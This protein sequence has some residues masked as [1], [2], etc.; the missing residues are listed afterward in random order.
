M[1]MRKFLAVG[2]LITAIA[3]TAFAQHGGRTA[4]G[5]GGSHGSTGGRHGA[6]MSR[7]SPGRGIQRGVR[8]RY[9]GSPRIQGYGGANRGYGAEQFSGIGGVANR[10]IYAG[11]G[12]R[13]GDRDGD[14]RNRGYGWRYGRGGRFG[15]G[16]RDRGF[17]YMYPYGYGYGYPLLYSGLTYAGDLGY[18]DGGYDTGTNGDDTNDGTGDDAAQGYDDQPPVPFSQGG[19]QDEGPAGYAGTSGYSGSSGDS[20]YPVNSGG[21]RQEYGA[22]SGY[23]TGAGYSAADV[24][25]GS[26]GGPSGQTTRFAANRAAD[27][28]L[29]DSAAVTLVFKDGRSP[30]KIHNYA[31]TRTMLYVTDAQP[32]EIPVADLDLPATEKVNNEAG[33]KFQLPK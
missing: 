32:Q 13:D 7:V 16:W 10:P 24:N 8:Q 30:E 22:R 9:G 19:A 28:T 11:R 31:L 33:V 5:N 25:R 6:G 17:P 2:I 4:G 14:D 1:N 26:T 18:G 15:D 12:R 29:G 20:A 23:Q 27:P 3:S 21:A